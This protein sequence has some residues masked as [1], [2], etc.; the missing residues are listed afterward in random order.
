MA[1][2]V[3]DM[4]L[5]PMGRLG[6]MKMCHMTADSHEELMDMAF[7][8][9]LDTDWLQHRG[10]WKEHF[11]IALGK[12]AK[13]LTLGAVEVTMK[14]TVVL[15]KKRWENLNNEKEKQNDN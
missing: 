12:R 6:R 7:K 2:Y 1:V 10:T 3:D 14:A 15:A 4:H 5:Y 11:D 9:D 8:L 13:A